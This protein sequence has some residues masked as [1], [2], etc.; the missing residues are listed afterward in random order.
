MT[1]HER[2]PEAGP[3]AEALAKAAEIIEVNTVVEHDDYPTVTRDGLV[4]DIAADI[5]TRRATAAVEHH[6]YAVDY[7][8]CIHECED[9]ER[10][11]AAAKQ[12]AET[13]NRNSA[14][15]F[16]AGAEAAELPC[17]VTLPPNTVRL[18]PGEPAWW[19]IEADAIRAAL[20][21]AAHARASQQ[22]GK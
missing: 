2:T 14:A 7:T 1:D 15:A 18:K 19:T 3:S 11:I 13:A 5:D 8:G 4:G 21:D 16:A 17:D 10:V 20:I 9:E 22:G 12:F 6:Y